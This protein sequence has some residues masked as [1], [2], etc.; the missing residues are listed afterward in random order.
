MLK[1]FK[2]VSLILVAG[3]LCFPKAYADTAPVKSE[4]NASLQSG[5]ITGT[6][7]D[8]FGPVAGASVVVKGTTN[9]SITDMDGKFTLEGVK[10][11]DIIQISFIGYATKEIKFEGQPSLQVMLAEDTQ[12][13][14]E[15]VVTA[16]GIKKDAKKLGY[17]V[18]TISSEDLVKTG[19]PN[20]ATSLYG[21]ASG[22]RIQA[23]PGGSSSAVSINVRGMS[24]I[25][26]T[27]QPL[28]IVDGVPIRNGDA[29]KDGYW[30]DQRVNSNGLVDIN[31]EDI[32][33]LSILKGAS[34][35]ALYGSEA[36]NGVVMITTKSGKGSSG[37]GVD[38]NATISGDWVAY[39]PEMQ[40][41]FGPGVAVTSRTE[42][43]ERESGG[44]WERT[45]DNGQ[46]VK[47]IR[48]TTAQF[49]PKY[50]GS[51][52]YYWD[53][54]MRK[55][56]P[57]SSNPWKDIFRTG[58]NQTYNLAITQGSEKGNMRFS[59]TYTDNTPTQYNSTYNKHNFSLSGSYSLNKALKLDYT[60]NYM[61]EDIKNRPYRISRITNNF[62]GMFGSF[63]DVKLMRETAVTSLGYLNVP[64]T[65]ESITPNESYAWEQ[66]SYGGLLTEY[67][68]NIYGKEQYEKNNRLIASATPT[69]N[70]IDGL[71][72]RGRISTDLTVNKIENQEKT[73]KPIAFGT[74]T[75]KYGLTN[76]QY[77]IYYGDI[78]LMF[79]RTFADKWNVTANAGWQARQ[80]S[81]YNANAFTDG[82]LSI[83]NWFYLNASKNKSIAGMSKTDFLK[84]AFLATAS[85]SYG[86][87]AYLEG[88]VRQEKTS[89]LAKGNNS[90]VYP[91]VNGSFIYTEAF[92]DQ[93]P[94]WYDYGKVRLS[95]GIVGNAP[96]IYKAIQAYTQNSISGYIYNQIP[97]ALGNEKIRPEEKHEFEIGLESKFFNNRLGF[98]MSY[99]TNTTKDQILETT[100]PQS[101]GG[102]SILQ[103]V[104][105]LKNKGFELSLYGTPIETKDWRWDIRGNFSINRNKVTKLMDGLDVLQHS[106]ID[107]GAATI[108]S[109]VGEPMGD[110]Y[111]YAPLED[112]NGNPIVNSDGFY[113]LTEERVKVGNAM[114]KITGGVSTSVSY[115]NF[116]LDATFDFRVGGAVLNIPYEYMM[117]RGNLVESMD[118]RDA[119]HG[120]L[121][122][123]FEGNNPTTGK[124][125]AATGT[126]GPNGE[127]VYDNG[128]ILGG[129]KADGSQNDII[130]PADKY[131][132]QTYNWGTDYPTYYSH[133]VFD[134]TY[135][136]LRELS[137]GY[138]LPKELT[139]KF[140]CR[141]LT[142][143][144]FGR[145]LFYLYKNLPAFDAEATDGT[146]WVSQAQIGG[147][148]ATTR[149]FG[150]SL[151]ASF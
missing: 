41:T 141:N 27:N 130:I 70:I 49:G 4:V 151:R 2:P 112:E 143:S 60:V 99:Y 23:A 40:T 31:P 45:L 21:K 11:G 121:N 101:A 72:L 69:W 126:A 48:T 37:I 6:V 116:Y 79:D 124:C 25:T 145:N 118:Y 76:K 54:T 63:E 9:G 33:N 96:E 28:V 129:V 19:T 61:L 109:H 100:I 3:A 47:S 115:K 46:T 148:T 144:V 29:N 122:Y 15:V 147:S 93:M 10:N 123:Y 65:Q 146:S 67:F 106:N 16:L 103:N 7:E 42:G 50:D 1:N 125:I 137:L 142:V 104:G 12:K 17:A 110:I 128:M 149:T 90:F 51:D 35:S 68:W 44:F 139:S 94:S 82:G 57:I 78:M 52:V 88:T 18:S 113:K 120:G 66:A 150:F 20:F 89:T 91:S 81:F 98:E 87:F 73:E 34:A 62:G 102:T 105:E 5:K 59:Y 55:Y 83:E 32:E 131:Y 75:G 14:D 26:G 64:S 133:S 80:E 114:P 39:M 108:E 111:A 56:S 84:T 24:S 71:I 38:F 138:T 134:N 13:L 132:N 140:A 74:Y 36:A 86:S 92:K 135:I 8:E 77:S 119:E 85:V 58:F 117:G 127:K 136:K 30:G 22:V 53:G 107:G 97:Q 95:Y 43:Y